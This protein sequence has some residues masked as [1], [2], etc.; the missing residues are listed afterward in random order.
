VPDDYRSSPLPFIG[1]AFVKL[2]ISTGAAKRY[3][4]RR[5]TVRFKDGRRRTLSLTTLRLLAGTA[6]FYSGARMQRAARDLG[7]IVAAADAQLRDD[8]ALR[9]EER[10][11]RV[12][13]VQGRIEVV[14]ARVLEIFSEAGDVLRLED[15]E[16]QTIDLGEL[17]RNAI[18]GSVMNS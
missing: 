11:A 5:V 12:G 7:A 6:A 9:E 14:K 10:V 15:F 8:P 1:A 3:L 13:R 4:H 18:A 16:D 17:A 2:R